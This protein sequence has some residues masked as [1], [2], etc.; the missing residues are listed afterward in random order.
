MSLQPTD[1]TIVDHL[2]QQ[3]PGFPKTQKGRDHYITYDSHGWV[4]RLNLSRRGLTLSPI[5]LPS[6]LEPQ[7]YH[8]LLATPPRSGRKVAPSARWRFIR[9]YANDLL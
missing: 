8:G 7:G 5:L 9:S 6:P 2:I 3:I 4:Q 1:A